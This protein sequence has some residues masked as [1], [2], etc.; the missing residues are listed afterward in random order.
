MKKNI[1]AIIVISVLCLTMFSACELFSDSE[2]AQTEGPKTTLATVDNA[3][4]TTVSKTKKTVIKYVTI[5]P[6]TVTDKNGVPVTDK[7]GNT[8][9]AKNG[10]E[11][12]STDKTTVKQNSKTF[13]KKTEKK[14]SAKKTKKAE[15]AKKTKKKVT[16]DK[17]KKNKE[18]TTA[19]YTFE[20]DEN[21]DIWSPMY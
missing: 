1:L 10:K 5:D 15:K 14:V 12:V 20:T 11:K 21:G 3:K 16:E 2:K 13:A 17:T 4:T 7:N 6:D 8:V 19:E 18:K 9:K